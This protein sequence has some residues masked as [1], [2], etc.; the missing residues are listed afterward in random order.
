MSW[1]RA[2]RAYRYTNDLSGKCA[3][4]HQGITVT[5]ASILCANSRSS[6]AASEMT[7][8]P[9]TKMNGF[10]ASLIILMPD[11]DLLHG[12]L[13]SRFDLWVAS[14]HTLQQCCHIFCHI[15]QNRTRSSCSLQ[16]EMHGGSYL[17]VHDI[18]YDKIM[19]CDW[20]CNTCISISWKA[21]FPRSC[22][23]ITV[24]ATI[25]IESI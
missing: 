15:D 14:A 21:V 10:F 22:C 2:Y 1:F 7:A 9:P 11:P 12:Y 23:H 18:L 13:F 4:S 25:G 6:S 16:Y 17:P 5:G 19:L 24:I 20:H 8:P 3:F